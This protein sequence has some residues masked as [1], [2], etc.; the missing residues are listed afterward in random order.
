MAE[1]PDN[2]Q[3]TFPEAVEEAGRL[4]RHATARLSSDRLRPGV[5]LSGGLDFRTILGFIPRRPVTTITFGSP[6]CRDVQ[7]A[8]RIAAAVGSE[9]HWF[10][11]STGDWVREFAD[12]HMTLTEGHHSWIHSH[13][14]NTLPEARSWVDVELTGWD[15]GTVMGHPLA[16]DHRQTQAVDDEAL[17]NYMHAVFVR[18]STWPSLT[19]AEEDLL[20]LEPHRSELLG[21]ALASFREEMAPY[22]T[23]RPDI[24]AELFF[25]R[26]HTGRMT[27][28]M[29]T[30]KRSHMEV[31]FPFFDYQLMDFMFSLPSV[32]HGPR[33]L[34]RAML[35]REL[36]RLASLPSEHDEML[37][38][39][40]GL[41]RLAQAF[42]VK[43]RRSFNRHVRPVFHER[44]T[45]YADYENYLR[46]DLRVW[47]E[48]ILF[49]ARTS[50]RGLFDP[51]FLRSLMDRHLTGLEPW[52]IGKIAPIITY[53]M[54]L[55]QLVD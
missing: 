30:V 41:A 3:V 32:I 38:T 29:V 10:D 35:D 17:V 37:P 9:H 26:N 42:G 45:L 25:L 16:V 18:I 34:Y 1:I 47:A 7:F 46:R 50:D 12:L 31:R 39:A 8:A 33:R 28:N 49:D 48:E 53:E 55:R 23:L 40:R 19:D 52:T 4:L 36:P 20:Y 21:R 51:K 11:L 22:L 44:A 13:G 27:H 15:G 2:S 14:I 5:Y 54:M 6:D 24:R 43:L